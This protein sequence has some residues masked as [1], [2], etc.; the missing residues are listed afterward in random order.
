MA[1][2]RKKLRAE[3]HQ[4]LVAHRLGICN[5]TVP[6]GIRPDEPPSHGSRLL[7]AVIGAI[8]LDSGCNIN[9]L[10]DARS[11]T[12]VSSPCPSPP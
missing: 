12:W 7:Q 4:A 8:Y 11:L 10:S 6:Y 9:A 5:L 2:L 1:Y 3:E